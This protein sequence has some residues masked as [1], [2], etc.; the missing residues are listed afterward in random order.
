MDIASNPLPPKEGFK[1]ILQ[2]I[3]LQRH[4][5]SLQYTV[6]DD[7]GCSISQINETFLIY[8]TCDP[9]DNSDSCLVHFS[10]PDNQLTTY[11]IQRFDIEEEK[12]CFYDSLGMC[13][14]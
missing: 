10:C 11:S 4:F 7:N 8:E 13:N 3:V 2:C 12:S 5:S 9:V 1:M 14:M 6:I